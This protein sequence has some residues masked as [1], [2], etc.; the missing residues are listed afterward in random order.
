MGRLV[1]TLIRKTGDRLGENLE[2]LLKAV[3]SKLSGTKTLSVAQ[4][5]LMVFAQLV[6]NQ[7]EALLNFLT[8]VPGPNGEAALEFVL[9]K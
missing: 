1:T 8:A 7:M 3:L 5:L 4:S 2:N 9:S 6:H